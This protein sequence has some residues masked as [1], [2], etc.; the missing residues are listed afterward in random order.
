MKKT[1]LA[2]SPFFSAPQQQKE[3]ATPP[4][5]DKPAVRKKISKDASRR[6]TA[7]P[8]TQPKNRDTTTPRNHDTTTP[9]NHDTMVSRYHDTIIELVRVAVKELGKEAAT[10]RFT[11]EEKRILADIIYA[12]KGQG[13]KTSENEITRVAI[14]FIISDYKANGK[15]SILDR[16]LKAL[17]K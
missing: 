1:G 16:T 13:L 12:Y 5:M 17:N 7:T 11:Q 3:E 4:P 8:P 14:N 9:S 15:N 6:E 2:D 10:H